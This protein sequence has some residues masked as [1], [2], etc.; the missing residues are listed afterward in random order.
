MDEVDSNFSVK[1]RWTVLLLILTNEIM[2]S[3]DN[4]YYCL[5]HLFI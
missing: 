2:R 1:R 4:L 5:G 3:K